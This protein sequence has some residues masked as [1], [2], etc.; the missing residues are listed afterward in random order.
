M[1]YGITIQKRTGRKPTAISLCVGHQTRFVLGSGVH[2]V[3]LSWTVMLPTALWSTPPP[4]TLIHTFHPPFPSYMYL[5]LSILVGHPP[6]DAHWL[7]D[8][9]GIL[10]HFLIDLQEGCGGR[11]RERAWSSGMSVPPS[12]YTTAMSTK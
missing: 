10:T 7:K 4:L 2:V 5:H 3:H 12:L 6:V 8:V 1:D 9:L 11:V